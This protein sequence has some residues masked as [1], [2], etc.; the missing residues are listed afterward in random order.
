MR[1]KILLGLSL[2]LVTISAMA[3]SGNT[4]TFMLKGVLFNDTT[5]EREPYAT[6]KVTHKAT[7]EKSVKVFVSDINGKFQEK[8]IGTGD[9]IFT[10]TSIG[11]EPLIK[12]F[13][14]KANENII[15]LG[16]LYI[17]NATNQ[18]QEVEVKAQKLL[19]KADIDK[20]QYNVEDDPDSK[21]N[22]VLE[23][24]RKVP[25]V[26]VDGEDKITV[27]GSSNF[28]I[29][30]NGK[31]N[32]MMT[33]NPS[34]VLK[35]MPANSIKRIEVIT[36]PGV[37]EDG[38]GVGGILNIITTQKSNMEGYSLTISGNGG[39]NGAGGGVFG[40]VSKG[41]FT[42]SARYNYR[43]N[44]QPETK[45]W[46]SQKTTGNITDKSYDLDSKG[47]IKYDNN[48]QWGNLEASYE[49][50]TLRLITMSFGLW[51]GNRNVN[52]SL[53]NSAFKPMLVPQEPLYSYNQNSHNKFSWSSIDG[54][55][56]YQRL[57]SVKERMLTFSYKVNTNP[58]SSDAY[59]IYDIDNTYTT[60]WEEYLKSLKNQHNNGTESTIENTFQVDY[61]TPIKKIHSIEVGAKYILRNNTSENNRYLSNEQSEYIFDA[62][63]SMNYK[64]LNNI[65]G[66]YAG[67]SFKLKKFMGKAGLRY[68]Y[69]S[70]D[71]TYK[72]GRGDD[73]KTS[74]NDFLPAVTVGWKITQLS[75]LKVG[76]N[77]RIQRPGIWYLNPYLNNDKP[78]NL[79]QGNPNLKSEKNH[80][81]NLTYSNFTEKFNINLSARY[82]FTDNGIQQVT[83][84]KNDNDIS[85]VPIPTG[86]DVL[87]S[88][89]DNSGQN[90]YVN[91]NA[92]VNWNASKD[93]R[94]Y[95]NLDGGYCNL[96]GSNNQKNDGWSL[97]A[98]G[99]AQQ[100][101]K[102]DWQV[103]VNVYG[104]TKSVSLQNDYC[105][106]VSYSL[107]INKSFLDKKLTISL[108]AS[109]FFNDKFDFKETNWGDGFYQNNVSQ[110][111]RMRFRVSVSYRLGEL[112]AAV[113]KV[114]R[115]IQNDDVKSG[116]SKSSDVK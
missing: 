104:R 55:I 9:F 72:L 74:F 14:V 69:T 52:N 34:D 109:D 49:I 114:A 43:Y 84:L 6:I 53:L 54:S 103:S 73:F 16:A 76:Y 77:M 105:G 83:T 22:T 27:N 62:T 23:M 19:V 8:I 86:K 51:G 32:N 45:T 71:V 99:G 41:K 26:T 30:I 60:D 94:V 79:S 25:L 56:D 50:D 13:S 57:F 29:Q 2:I 115:S 63:N 64:H 59:S 40:M 108:S 112:K 75:T 97:S 7:P 5:K 70:Q 116:E 106:F 68:E 38:E 15:D 39:N 100:S 107:N 111:S 31:P 17:K 11:K 93:T 3:Q 28:K 35:S 82:S 102:H 47:K 1:N 80:N 96:R 88:T 78:T 67:Y 66:A 58:Q 113:K 18:L 42:M 37:K 12:P 92:Y 21:I 33:K 87:Y 48:F 91:L 46:S 44:T 89:Y 81:I 85:G 24:L 10:A 20:I 65:F 4:Q 36:D 61:T 98:Y 90:K 110:I 101:F 95:L